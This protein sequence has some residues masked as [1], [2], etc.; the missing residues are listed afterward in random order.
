MVAASREKKVLEI[1][2]RID[3][4]KTDNAGNSLS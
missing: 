4:C 2:Q 3:V 1:A